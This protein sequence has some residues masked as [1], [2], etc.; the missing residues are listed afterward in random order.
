MASTRKATMVSIL[1]KTWHLPKV[2]LERKKNAFWKN[3]DIQYQSLLW[4]VDAM[5]FVVSF[6]R[7]LPQNMF[8]PKQIL[9]HIR[10]RISHTLHR[11][12]SLVVYHGSNDLHYCPYHDVRSTSTC[13]VIVSAGPRPRLASP[14]ALPIAIRI[15]ATVHGYHATC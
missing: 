12:P 4:V 2:A 7:T 13:T 14:L 6:C 9:V 15:P 5:P 1:A 11:L 3:I 10:A 8:P